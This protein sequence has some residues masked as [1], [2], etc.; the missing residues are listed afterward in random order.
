I[1]ALL[2]AASFAAGSPLL[3]TPLADAGSPPTEPPSTAPPSTA[4]PSTAPAPT[5][6]PP[7]TAPPLTVPATVHDPACV[8]AVQ[9]GDSISLISDRVG[10]EIGVLRGE[11]GLGPDHVLRPGDLLD[12]CAGND[13]DDITGETR[14]PADIPD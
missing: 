8:V 14:L 5:T 6:A 3:G 4:P 7:T 2:L 9:P 1:A 12:I 10:V 13:V 11:N